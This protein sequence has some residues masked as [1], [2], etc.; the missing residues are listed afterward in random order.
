MQKN[1][2]PSS[3][4]DEALVLAYHQGD[5]SALAELMVRYADWVDQKVRRYPELGPDAEDAKQEL[6]VALVRAVTGYDAGKGAAFRTYLNRCMENA[7]TSFLLNRQTKKAAVLRDAV[8]IDEVDEQRLLSDASA[9]PEDQ[10]ILQERF[11]TMELLIAQHLSPFE[12][13]VLFYYLAE[14]SYEEI[15]GSLHCSVKSVD[16]ALQRIR[17]KL[18]T[19]FHDLR[20]PHPPKDVST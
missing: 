3:R 2:S 12:Q 14:Y 19:V 20:E 8:P 9:N 11:H 1:F 13:E 18:K 4:S 6:M 7:M 10:I 5:N 16:N 17:R 15:A